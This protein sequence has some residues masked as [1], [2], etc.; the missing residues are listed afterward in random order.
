MLRLTCDHVPDMIRCVAGKVSDLDL[1]TPD[2]EDI[3]ILEK[4]VKGLLKFLSRDT[5]ALPERL[6]DSA[7]TFADADGRPESLLPCQSV[8]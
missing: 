3:A 5:V 8:L 1:Q 2:V 4:K 6:L 7:D